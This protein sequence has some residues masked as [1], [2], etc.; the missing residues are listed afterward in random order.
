MMSNY[1]PEVT[2]L[3]L[4]KTM[5]QISFHLAL[6]HMHSAYVLSFLYTCPVAS[7]PRGMEISQEH[8]TKG[9]EVSFKHG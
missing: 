1:M 9:I 6:N 2:K 5:L 8:F 7:V 4:D 3:E